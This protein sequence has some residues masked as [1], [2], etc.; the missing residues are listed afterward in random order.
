MMTQFQGR[1]SFC[2]VAERVETMFVDFVSS[3][4]GKDTR[5]SVEAELR[6]SLPLSRHSRVVRSE[7][8]RWI[9]RGSALGIIVIVCFVKKSN[10]AFREKTYLEC[11]GV[12]WGR[13]FSF[14]G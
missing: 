14:I 13:N 2:S 7:V 8:P 6:E 4:H 10:V 9:I 1:T 11:C 3:G 12:C 5:A